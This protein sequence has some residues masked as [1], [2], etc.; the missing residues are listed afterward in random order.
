MKRNEVLPFISI[1]LIS[2]LLSL[3]MLTRGHLWWDDFASYIL[4]AQSLLHGNPQGFVAHNAFTIQ[5]S[6][7]PPGPIA[8]PWGFPILLTPVL[9]IFGMKLLALKGLN[10]IFF[11]FFLV[12]FYQ[13]TRTR[14]APAWSLFLTAILAFNPVLLQA[15]DLILSDIPFLFFSTLTLLLIEKNR[16]Q[17][18]TIGLVIFFAFSLRTNGL[19]L[20]APLAVAQIQQVHFWAGARKD[21]ARI[22]APY[23]SFAVLAGLLALLLPGGQESYFSHFS[24]FTVERWLANAGYYLRLPYEFFKDLWLGPIFFW[25]WVPLFFTG[26]IFNFKRDLSL[27]AYLVVSLGLFITWPETQG[28]RF[29]YPLAPIGAL[30][31]AEGWNSAAER[32]PAEGM[33]V[34]RWAGLG[35]AG[36]LILLSLT[37]S[38]QTGMSNLRNGRDINGPFD[39]YS[40][41]MFA[42]IR[43][44]TPPDGVVVF[45]RP[46][47]MR[48][49]GERDSFLSTECARLPMGDY[50]VLS[51]KADDSLQ[52]PE[53][54]IQGC[55][56]SLTEVFENRRFIVFRLTQ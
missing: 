5:Q 19:L 11:L 36:L 22:V 27:L 24:M 41:E 47:A 7:Y 38:A 40:Q 2:A 35:S 42:F 53:N 6:S 44:Q 34:A 15:H 37:A 29:L 55:G 8:Y 21:W 31:A 39:I 52:I 45:F 48:L 33:S 28:L 12:V 18:W 46:R 49:L 51:K 9:A 43:E 20:L 13:L 4:Q 50:L 10:T 26:V 32:L 16:K 56:L 30:I 14:L 54:Q 1:L 23:I 17:T 3:S 25:L